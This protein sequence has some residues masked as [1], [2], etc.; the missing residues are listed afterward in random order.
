MP[1]PLRPLLRSCPQTKP[2]LRSL[3]LPACSLS[4]PL[5]FTLLS[6]SGPLSV[7]AKDLGCLPRVFAHL[8]P[9]AEECVPPHS[10]CLPCAGTASGK[11]PHP[12]AWV[13]PPP[14]AH[15]PLFI[16]FVA[17]KT[18]VIRAMNC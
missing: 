11:P 7:S 9:F 3:S 4:L 17:W 2:Q 6:H 15:R 5:P 1:T 13:R 18:I 14:L 10:S 16:T 12:P 8:A